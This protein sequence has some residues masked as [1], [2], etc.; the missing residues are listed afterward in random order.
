M[1]LGFGQGRDAVVK[2]ADLKQQALALEEQGETA[3]AVTIYRHI[4]THLEG[5]PAIK[6]Q[7]G[8]YLKV[9]DMLLGAGDVSGALEMYDNAGDHLAASGSAQRVLTVA[10]KIREAAPQRADVFLTL[11]RRM[12]EHGHAGPAVDLLMR[13]AKL[14]G[15]EQMLQEL[16]PLADRPS[17]DVKPQVLMILE[18]ME[19]PVEQP[20]AP[21]PAPPPPPP[22]TKLAPL[23]LPTWAQTAS[24]PPP[25]S[26]PAPIAPPPLPPLP[27]TAAPLSTAPLGGSDLPPD[28]GPPAPPTPRETRE[29]QMRASRV[30]KAVPE[31]Q[32]PP[33]EAPSPPPPRP[34]RVSVQRRSVPVS[35]PRRRS[36]GLLW[37]AGLVLVA[38]TGVW[39]AFSGKL[40]IADVLRSAGISDEKQ[41]PADSRRSTARA[42]RRELPRRPTSTAGASAPRLTAPPVVI[43]GLAVESFALLPGRNDA[44][45]V[46]HQQ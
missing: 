14:A 32:A 41:R 23:E 9:G 35:V 16:Q 29:I 1:G 22:L 15:L 40:P 7:L 10:T 3:K 34:S 43:G 2:V 20:V 19:T 26:A 25:I 5:T 11:A 28:F 36:A 24:A 42:P 37:V 21:A 6:E 33:P 31:E 13:H 39:L 45:L 46:Q 30:F 8:L 38:G 4:L 18:A 12:V 44:Y 17:D 27:E